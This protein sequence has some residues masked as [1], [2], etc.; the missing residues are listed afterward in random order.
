MGSKISRRG[1]VQSAAGAA[2]VGGIVNF[3]WGQEQ[4]A[5]DST[6]PGERVNVG[7]IGA[8][9]QGR[10]NIERC[11]K[12]GANM[13]ALCDVDEKRLNDGAKGFEKTNKYTD[14]RKMLAQKD[15]DA[16]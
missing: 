1:F 9:G 6:S 11:D 5:A 2:F 15:I 16:V 4:K 12:A 10:S 13:V 3:A 14:F 8:N 7:V